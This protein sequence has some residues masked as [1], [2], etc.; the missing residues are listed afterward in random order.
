MEIGFSILLHMQVLVMDLLFSDHSPLSIIVED[1][2]DTK[3]RPFKFYNYLVQ[4]PD[5]RTKVKKD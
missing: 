1:H 3:K 4:H 5:F 2:V